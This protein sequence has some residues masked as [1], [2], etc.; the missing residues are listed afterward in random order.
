MPATLMTAH[1]ALA[2]LLCY[3][4][5]GL[6]EPVAQ[7]VASLAVACPPASE[8]LREFA[9]FVA[10]TPQHDLEELFTRTFDN[11]ADRALEIGW[12]LH[13][14]T[15]DRGAFLVVMRGRLRDL[16]ITENSELPDHLSHGLMV[17]GRE[18]ADQ[19]PSLALE[20]ILPAVIKIKAGLEKIE[21]P[22]LPV[23]DGIECLLKTYETSDQSVNPS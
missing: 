23:L 1:E 13:G 17:L 20:A 9:E 21:S 11:V 2:G 4:V 5:K 10:V 12:H 15:Y 6:T 7:A 22:Y 16:G 8:R 3:P 18:D 19:A 14:E